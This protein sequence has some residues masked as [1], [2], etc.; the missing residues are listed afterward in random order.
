MRVYNTNGDTFDATYPLPATNWAYIGLP[1]AGRGYI[2]RDLVGAYG[3]IHHFALRNGK[4]S[5][6]HG[7]GAALNFTLHTDPRP[8]NIV[9]RY[10]N[11]FDCLSYG[12]GNSQTKFLA[13]KRYGVKHAAPPATCP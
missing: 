6:L 13:D 9:L 8:V 12:G 10:G 2:Y 3:P 7:A 4:A 5:N 11:L 1:E